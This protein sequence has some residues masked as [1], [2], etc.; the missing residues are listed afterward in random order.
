MKHSTCRLTVVVCACV[1]STLAVVTTSG[2]KRNLGDRINQALHGDPQVLKEH[3]TLKKYPI[4]FEVDR[5]EYGF[6]PLP[7]KARLSVVEDGRQLRVTIIKGLNRT[8]TLLKNDQ[9]VW[10][11]HHEK[12]QFSGPNVYKGKNVKQHEVIQIEYFGFEKPKPEVRYSYWGEN[13]KLRTRYD[14]T[15]E[16][17]RQY[18]VK[19]GHHPAPPAAGSTEK[20]SKDQ[21]P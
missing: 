7:E 9:G 17:V 5:E 8:I 11:W 14:L 19:W 20:G 1:I 12:Q 6:T 15:L 18:L 21:T 16:E 10:E 2:C 13:P 4:L 3:A